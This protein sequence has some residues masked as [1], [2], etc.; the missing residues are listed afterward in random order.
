MDHHHDYH[1]EHADHG[2][3]E[4]SEVTPQVSY[5]TGVITIELKDKNNEVPELDVSHEKNMHL[6]IVSSDL[7][8]YYHLHPKEKNSGAYSQEFTLSDNSYKVFV[9][10]KPKGLNYSVEPIELNVG[11]AHREHYENQ[12]VK[13]TNFSKTINGQTV[14]LT[15]RSFEVNKEISLNFDVKGATPEPYLGALG[16][17]IILDEAGKKFIHVH[18]VSNKKSVFKTQFNQ[19]GVYK[20]WV[21]F[22]FGEKVNAYPYVIEV[23]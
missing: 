1:N 7:K 11:E 23:N 22:K 19:P 20:L 15:T 10:I 3:N 6:I 9:D 5:D 4:I 16:H 17:V 21:E 18:P 12:L 14:E 8:E 2:A 13:D